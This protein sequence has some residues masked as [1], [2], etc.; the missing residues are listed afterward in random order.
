MYSQ[1]YVWEDVRESSGKVKGR[2][3]IKVSTVFFLH[4][5]TKCRIHNVCKFIHKFR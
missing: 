2:R 3:Y 5:R 4:D 1:I